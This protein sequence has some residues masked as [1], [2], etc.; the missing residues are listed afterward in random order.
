MGRSFSFDCLIPG[1]NPD[2]PHIIETGRSGQVSVKTTDVVLT[3][4]EHHPLIKKETQI[5]LDL[6][7]T[8]L[9]IWTAVPSQ[10]S[11]RSDFLTGAG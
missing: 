9:T 10:Y 4:D 3:I 8:V 5:S 1:K 11:P 6:V 2:A 7:S